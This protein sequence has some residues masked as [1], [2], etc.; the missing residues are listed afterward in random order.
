V[1]SP[2]RRPKNLAGTSALLFPRDPDKPEDFSHSWP[3]GLNPPPDERTARQAIAQDHPAFRY[4]AASG[5]LGQ[6]HYDPS[7][8]TMAFRPV[9]PG[10]ERFLE[11]KSLDRDSSVRQPLP[12][13]EDLGM[14]GVLD[15]ARELQPA[16]GTNAGSARLSNAQAAT[17]REMMAARRDQTIPDEV[18][19]GTA[20]GESTFNPMAHAGPHR[21]LFQYDVNNWRRGDINSVANQVA[22]FEADYGRNRSIAQRATGARPPEPWEIYMIHQQGIVGGP[23]LLQ[24]PANRSAVEA[25]ADAVVRETGGDR[26]RALANARPHISN[27]MPASQRAGVPIDQ[28]TAAQFRDYLSRHYGELLA[29]GRAILQQQQRH[30]ERQ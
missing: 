16:N 2:P 23:A 9:D 19:A 30:Q 12:S 25:I 3:H 13:A 11:D 6:D 5:R 28:V 10:F 15:A 20:Y 29:Q 27:N 4:D 26:A 18:L 1:P 22:Q 21:G 17:F 8:R 7:N 14:Q 24:A